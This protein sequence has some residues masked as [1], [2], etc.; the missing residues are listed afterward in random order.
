MAS[1]VITY[2]NTCPKQWNSSTGGQSYEYIPMDGAT[3]TT[4]IIGM[5]YV[6]TLGTVLLGIVKN[7]N[8]I[9]ATN[10]LNGTTFTSTLLSFSINSSG[11]I[12][13]TTSA[14]LA[15]MTIYGT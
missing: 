7:G 10:L 11:H 13:I 5:G 4:V 15:L 2:K 3:Y 6:A 12:V 1:G 8:T 9:T 14:S